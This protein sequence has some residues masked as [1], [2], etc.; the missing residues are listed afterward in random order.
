MIDVEN[1]VNDPEKAP[2]SKEMKESEFVVVNFGH[3]DLFFPVTEEADVGKIMQMISV[4]MKGAYVARYSNAGP[5]KIAAKHTHMAKWLGPIELS[6]S[7]KT[8]AYFD[9]DVWIE[10][11][12]PLTISGEPV[13]GWA[14]A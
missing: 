13:P 10:S 2:G 4:F 11:P 7:R 1:Q 3:E 12:V 6:M 14:A 5:S 8:L 9:R